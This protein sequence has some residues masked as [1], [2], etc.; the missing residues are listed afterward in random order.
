M[1]PRYRRPSESRRA[2]QLSWA[3]WAAPTA[4]PVLPPWAHSLMA[5]LRLRNACTC[6][7]PLRG[8]ALQRAHTT[9]SP[10]QSPPAR[11]RRRRGA[12]RRALSAQRRSLA[13]QRAQAAASP[14]QSLPARL[15]RC[16]A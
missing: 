4:V 3:E 5:H 12:C 10:R 1:R 14:Q 8:L 6:P 2:T 9:A 13:L 11:L 16:R 7:A 15:R